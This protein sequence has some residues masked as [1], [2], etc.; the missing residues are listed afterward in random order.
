MTSVVW[1]RRDARLDDNPALAAAS[2]E[3][4]VCALFVIDPALYDNCSRRR[5]DL[6]VAG[7][8]D[9][10]RT[11]REH[12]GRLRVERGDPAAV[13]PKVARDLG[14]GTV[15]INSEVTPFGKA[16]DRRVARHVNVEGHH[17]V[18]ALPSGSVT[19]SGDTA[20]K[21]FTPF[22][23]KWAERRTQP[24]DRPADVVFLDDPGQGLP[25]A[26]Q[27]VMAAGESAANQRLSEFLARVDAYEDERDHVDLDR[28]SHLSIDLKYGWLGPRR[29]V[30]EVGT[31]TAS[32]SAYV[33][34]LAW[35]DFYGHLIDVQPQMIDTA[36]DERYRSIEWHDDPGEISAW[37]RGE[38]GYP[39]VD[40]AMRRLLV[41]GRM[42]NRARMIAASFLTK[43]LLADWRIGERFF[44]HHLLD[45]DVAQNAG[46]WQWV[47]G[48]GT[49]AAPYFRVFNPVTQSKRHDPNGKFIRRWVPE[50]RD[51]PDDL[52]HAPWEAGPLELIS[53]GVELAK[54]YPEPIVDHAMA[55]VRAIDFYERARGSR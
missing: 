28:T 9:L 35:R 36:L 7:L 12:G 18:Y 47:A 26:D 50:L 4:P 3:G 51:V 49:D 14:V 32:R 21:I 40:A 1:F 23:S 20:Y 39:I 44:R 42:H 46:N 15:H 53:Y 17:G 16:R 10:D 30:A 11:I 48:T 54:N 37:K 45:G 55:R 27:P 52:I 38:T 41:E 13:V 24:F 8:V 43:D 29:I 34:Q 33:R 25:G 2:A 19:T 6:L 31:G 22:Y 5:G